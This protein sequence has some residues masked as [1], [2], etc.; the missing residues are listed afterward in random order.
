MTDDD[1]PA[2]EFKKQIWDEYVKPLIDYKAYFRQ[3]SRLLA[4]NEHLP[5]L[6]S[7][8]WR[9]PGWKSPLL[10]ALQ[11]TLVI[12]I[13]IAVISGFFSLFVKER[14]TTV[15]KVERTKDQA[16]IIPVSV[17]EGSAWSTR[18]KLIEQNLANTEA[19]FQKIR[20]SPADQQFLRPVPYSD[21]GNPTLFMFEVALRLTPVSRQEAE[22]AYQDE[23]AALQQQ[24]LTARLAPYG[25]QAAERLQ[26]I[27]PAIALVI[28]AYLFLWRVRYKPSLNGRVKEA[29]IA[30]LYLVSAQLFWVYFASAVVFNGRQ[31]LAQYF[32]EQFQTIVSD[33]GRA[34]GSIDH[35]RFWTVPIGQTIYYGALLILVVWAFVVVW[36]ASA[37]MANYFGVVDKSDANVRPLTTG[38]VFANVALAQ[39]VAGLVTSIAYILVVATYAFARLGLEGLSR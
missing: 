19:E 36:K 28:G 4:T 26:H 32:P 17:P 9:R 34:L 33:L 2:R 8:R 35:P 24:L 39:V 15:F 16:A 12:G 6:A 11:G 1:N 18:R 30:Y 25:E 10:F 20:H 7:T 5:D 3:R 27:V 13:A 29:H 37:Q 22:R 31:L 38:R 21:S 14:P 23:I